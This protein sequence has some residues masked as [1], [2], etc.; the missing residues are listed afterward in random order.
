MVAELAGET[1]L[2]ISL[3]LIQASKAAAARGLRATE[4]TEEFAAIDRQRDVIDGD[5]TGK[6]FRYLL[7]ANV[8]FSRGIVPRLPCAYRSSDR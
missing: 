2:L 6:A 5:E 1:T 8:R 4:Q 3:P 7:D